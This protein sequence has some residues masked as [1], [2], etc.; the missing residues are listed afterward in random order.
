[1]SYW[2]GE[3]V[4]ES[5]QNPEALWTRGRDRDKEVQVAMVVIVVH[6]Y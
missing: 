1:M 6:W 3:G 2:F 4:L 5:E